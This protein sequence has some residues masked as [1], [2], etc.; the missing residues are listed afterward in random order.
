MFE[1]VIN[2][3]CQRR[4]G[5]RAGIKCVKCK[6]ADLQLQQRLQLRGSARASA[7]AR[8]C[9]GNVK[10]EVNWTRKQNAAKKEATFSC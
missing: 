3:S 1:F 7:S 10:N 4:A 6:H 2:K 5:V 9:P 8:A